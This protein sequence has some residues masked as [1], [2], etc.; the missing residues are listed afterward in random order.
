MAKMKVQVMT[1]NSVQKSSK[2][3]L[4]S[5]TFDHFKVYT[6]TDYF[7]TKIVGVFRHNSPAIF[8]AQG[9]VVWARL[10]LTHDNMIDPSEINVQQRK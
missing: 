8:R 3:E 4:S 2:S 10:T 9:L 5:G 1:I 6:V 7:G